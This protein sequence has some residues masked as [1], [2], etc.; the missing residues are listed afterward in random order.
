V[1]PVAPSSTKPY[2]CVENVS[3]NDSHA[4]QL[5]YRVGSRVAILVLWC[6]RW[7]RARRSR[8]AAWRTSV[9][10]IRMP[11]KVSRKVFSVS[12][13]KYWCYLYE[14]GAGTSIDNEITAKRLSSVAGYADAGT[15]VD[16]L[17]CRRL[18]STY[19]GRAAIQKR[20][21][22]SGEFVWFLAL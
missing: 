2:R 11:A 7:H 22:N 1:H 21:H 14:M 12:S 15:S 4:A 5:R 17:M 9:P 10:M 20:V 16:W 13:A 18:R 6:I 8:I 3:A 19:R